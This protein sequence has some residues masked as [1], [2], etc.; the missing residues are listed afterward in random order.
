[1]RMG[2]SG[3]A[4]RRR[5][6]SSPSTPPGGPAPRITRRG[7][8]CRPAPA[9]AA[10]ARAYAD[11]GAVALSVLTDREFF[12]GSP[13]DLIAARD[14]V[15]LPVMRKDFTV[16]ERDVCDARIMGADAVLLIVAA[17]S[18]E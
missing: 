8:V 18:A 15:N 9:P 11:G 1:M 2:T 3:E 12:G 4:R 6:H 14:A 16:D 10:L 7:G 17:L 13:E 5:Q